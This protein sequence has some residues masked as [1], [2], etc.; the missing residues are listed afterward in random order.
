MR[1]FYQPVAAVILAG[2]A[3][4][5][6]PQPVEAKPERP[7]YA[8][9]STE[10]E[11][12]IRDYSTMVLAEFTMRGTYR[13]SVSQGY[14]KLE[15]YF[16]G[17]NTVPEPI[18]MTVPTM[19]RDDLSNGW[20]TM[21]FLPKGYRVESAPRPLDRR[22]RVIEYPS[23]RMAVIMFSGKLN[24][25]V[26]REQVAILEAWLAAKGIAH[27]NDFTLAGYATPWTPKR[28]RKNE[29]MVTLK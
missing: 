16:L 6:V 11:F 2:V 7:E 3:L 27:R 20:S 10:K 5:S 12:E 21:F 29:V 8:V 28:W 26:M 19:V 1:W 9:V 25:F 22:I 14:I 17:K 24:E 4:T 18:R 13:Q 15:Q 23:R